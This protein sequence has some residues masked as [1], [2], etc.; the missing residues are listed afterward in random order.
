MANENFNLTTFNQTLVTPNTQ[1]YLKQALGKRAGLYA[2]NILSVVSNSA[3]LQKCNPKSVIYAGVQAALNDLPLG[4]NL[5]LA[6]VIPYG[7]DAQ[8]QMGYK[9]YIQ[10]A[11]RSG[12]MRTINVREVKEGELVG[13]DFASGELQFKMLPYAKREKAK[14]I[15]FV[16]YFE[17][18]NGFHKMEY[19]S[20]ERLEQHAE[21]YSQTYKNYKKY[22]KGNCVWVS[23]FDAMAKKTVLKNLISKYAPL[24][25]QLQN[26]INADQAVFHEDSTQSYDDNGNGGNTFEELKAEVAAEQE[27]MQG[28]QTVSKEDLANAQVI[29]PEEISTPNGKAKE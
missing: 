8:F 12:Q 16:G 27:Q 15:G 1:E 19:W 9:G 20:V 5:G 7:Q 11:Q 28:K 29:E 23:N 10:L 21:Q 6:Y 22:R 25:V 18:T 3:I 26:A 2:S 4:N 13:E 14:T 17:L 24:S